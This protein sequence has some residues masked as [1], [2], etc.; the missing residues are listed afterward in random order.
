MTQFEELSADNAKFFV[1]TFYSDNILDISRVSL[2]AISLNLENL[3]EVII[4]THFRLDPTKYG[5]SLLSLQISLTDVFLKWFL[6]ILTLQELFSDC[7]K[8]ISCF[9]RTRGNV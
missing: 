1:H 4:M 3:L 2:S 5:Y 7:W 8:C 9:L 6:L